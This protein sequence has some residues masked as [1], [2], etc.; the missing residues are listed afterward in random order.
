[1]DWSGRKNLQPKGESESVNS[2]TLVENIELWKHFSKR[3]DHD[4]I[5]HSIAFWN[6]CCFIV[7]YFSVWRT[8]YTIA[9]KPSVLM[10]RETQIKMKTISISITRSILFELIYLLLLFINYIQL[11]RNILFRLTLSFSLSLLSFEQTYKLMYHFVQ[12]GGIVSTK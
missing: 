12:K 2:Y 1:M 5:D 6:C 9:D 3:K 10:R 4:W 7:H 11:F 8:T